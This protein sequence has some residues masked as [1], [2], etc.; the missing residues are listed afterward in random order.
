M[1]YKCY[2]CHRELKD[3]QT[4]CE[5]CG[6]IKIKVPK[7]EDIKKDEEVIE[8]NYIANSKYAP[9]LIALSITLNISFIVLAGINY[10]NTNLLFL[11]T[12]LALL[13]ILYGYM[14]F[15]NNKWIRLV[16]AIEAYTIFLILYLGYLLLKRLV[17]K[18]TGKNI[19]RS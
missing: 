1:S 14:F 4:K 9:Y 17:R 2:R 15:Q 18:V 6:A 16:S 10:T 11:F 8:Q 3:G 12:G 19:D 13:S 5:H 7:K